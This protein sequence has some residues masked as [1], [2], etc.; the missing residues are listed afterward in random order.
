MNRRA[1]KGNCR[2]DG[3]HGFPDLSGDWLRDRG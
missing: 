3:G 1:R 2:A